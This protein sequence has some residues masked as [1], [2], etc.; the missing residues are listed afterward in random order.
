MRIGI[1]KEI[2]IN[3]NRV[4]ITPAGVTTLSRA[5]HEV[6]IEAGAGLGSG[7]S[8]SEYS[9]SGAII[10][11]AAKEVWARAEMVMKVKEPLAQEIPFLREDLILFTYLH[12]AP[13]PEL[14]KAMMDSK[15]VGIAY[16]TVQLDSGALPL[17][18]PM[19]EVAG[20][21]AIQIGAHYLAKH[22]GN[23]AG[24]LLGGVP[25]VLSGHIVIIGSGIVGTNAAKV[26][27]GMG[28]RV[29]LFDVKMDRLRYLDDIFR[30]RVETCAANP[31][32]IAEA[33][34]TA[35]LIV[36]AVLIPGGRTPVLVTERMVHSMKAGSVMIDV[37]IDQGG[38]IE[39]MNRV[40][41]HA[42]P[43]FIR[44]DVIHY[45]VPNM[46]GA[47]PRTSTFA[48][49]NATLPYAV[50]LARHGWKAACQK[51]APLARGVNIAGGLCVHQGVAEA[52]SLPYTPVAG[53]FA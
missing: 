34:R 30:G 11:A 26:A 32:T 39:T 52:Q 15:T 8:D 1:P 50:E 24:I 19:S 36:G 42:D 9:A 44:H 27:V 41:S 38:C 45:A 2:K 7:I 53:L 5:G 12:L 35:D 21:M 16:E 20:K 23:G 22:D 46:P 51:S 6:F 49:T 13:E 25:G 28:A 48:L 29:T 18:E 10:V 4:A 14:T 47:V 43:I 17:L 31:H 37:A 40:T 33:V 3:E